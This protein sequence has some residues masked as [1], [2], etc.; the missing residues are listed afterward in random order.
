MNS[1][2]IVVFS[3]EII[4]PLG[5]K[6]SLEPAHGDRKQNICYW[7][8]RSSSKWSHSNFYPW[9]PD[10]VKLGYGHHILSTDLNHIHY[11]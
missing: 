10:L 8:T 1:G 4:H 5:I 6:V 2:I 7:N 3:D 11:L 9:I